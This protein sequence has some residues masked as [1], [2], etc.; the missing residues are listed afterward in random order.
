VKT[1]P[2]SRPARYLQHFEKVV[3][4]VLG[5]KFAQH[6]AMG[7]LFDVL[8]LAHAKKIGSLRGHAIGRRD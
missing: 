4:A 2:Q 7:A 6:L 8:A 1:A 3:M 5:K